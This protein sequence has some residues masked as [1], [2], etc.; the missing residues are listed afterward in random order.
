MISILSAILGCAIGYGIVRLQ[1]WYENLKK[2]AKYRNPQ[3]NN[4]KM[5]WP[6]HS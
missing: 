5:R 4:A 2:R 6:H 1:I 3:D